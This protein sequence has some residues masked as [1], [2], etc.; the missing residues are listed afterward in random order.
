[1]RIFQAPPPCGEDKH[2]LTPP[3]F[4]SFP[5]CIHKALP[6]SSNHLVASPFCVSTGFV[7]EFTMTCFAWKC[8]YFY[9]TRLEPLPVRSHVMPY[10]DFLSQVPPARGGSHWIHATRRLITPTNHVQILFLSSGINWRM[11]P[12]SLLVFIL[13]CSGQIK[14][15]F[16][17]TQPKHVQKLFI[18]KL[19]G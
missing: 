17:F 19:S 7:L 2:F 4:P 11:T 12:T 10:W 3:L 14:I 8:N 13:I 5:P 9:F 15:Y 18:R 1:M 6:K 16:S